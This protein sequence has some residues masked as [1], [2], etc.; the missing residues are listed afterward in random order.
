MIDRQKAATWALLGAMALS[1]CESSSTVLPRVLPTQTQE[2]KP[3]LVVEPSTTIPQ[4]TDR[5]TETP[6]P[7]STPETSPTSGV[8]VLVPDFDQRAIT[9]G[10]T[11]TAAAIEKKKVIYPE[12][13]IFTKEDCDT[14]RAASVVIAFYDD[15]RAISAYSGWVTEID[16]DSIYISTAAHDLPEKYHTLA[17][18]RP[19]MDDRGYAAA[20]DVVMIEKQYTGDIDQAVIRVP[21]EYQ[22][23]PNYGVLSS[24]DDIYSVPTDKEFLNIGFPLEYWGRQEGVY[25][26]DKSLTVCRIVKS[27]AISQADFQDVMGHGN[28]YWSVEGIAIQGYSGSPIVRKTP[29]GLKGIGLMSEAIDVSEDDGKTRHPVVEVSPLKTREM[30]DTIKAKL[31]K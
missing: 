14:L 8:S 17:I 22:D 27:T 4:P 30:I 26:P 13:E 3:T 21:R 24:S 23:W 2:P 19:Q 11:A 10:E 28:P 25:D 5:P 1:A 9:L 20:S 31:R 7:S 12:S 15:V 29:S 6:V 16:D 18:W